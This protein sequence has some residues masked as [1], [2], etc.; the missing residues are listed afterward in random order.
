MT[1]LNINLNN[2]P[3][4]ILATPDGTGSHM[5]MEPLGEDPL[6][7]HGLWEILGSSLGELVVVLAV[8][9][10][11]LEQSIRQW[12]PGTRLGFAYLEAN[13]AGSQPISAQ[14]IQAG[15]ATLPREPG[16]EAVMIL[17]ANMP[18]VCLETI[19]TLIQIYQGISPDAPGPSIIMPRWAKGNLPA[20]V[21]MDIISEFLA[22]CHEGNETGS[23][24]CSDTDSDIESDTE[25]GSQVLISRGNRVLKIGAGQSSQSLQVLT[26]QELEKAQKELATEED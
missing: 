3:G 23:E 17:G 19:D 4:L 21:P 12:F 20:L 5:L 10:R 7:T 2:I 25:V 6:F 11:E 16:P 24:T 14:A 15:L 9:D 8:A 18:F 1:E 22:A 13:D 26:P